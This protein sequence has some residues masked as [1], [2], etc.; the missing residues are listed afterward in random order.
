M[1]IELMRK[2]DYW[3]GIPLTALMTAWCRVMDRFRHRVAL[4]EVTRVLFIELSEMGSAILVDPALRTVAQ[5]HEVYFLIFK[6]NAASLRIF[7]TVADAN[8]CTIR[9]DSLVTLAWDTLRFTIWCRR[10]RID[11][12]VDLELFS[13]VTAILSALSGAAVRIGFHNP[14]SEGLYRGGILTHPVAYNPHV[15][16]A[17]NFVSLSDPIVHPDRYRDALNRRHIGHG[18]VRLAQVRPAEPAIERVRHILRRRIPALMPQHRLFLV[19]ANAGE[20]L[21]QRKWPK[22]HFARFIELFLERNADVLVLLTGSPKERADVEEIA[23]RVNSARCLNIAGDLDFEDLPALYAMA[24]ALLTN[25][26]GPAHFASA[27]GLRTY[28]LFG[29]ETPALYAPLNNSVPIYAGLACSP[30]VTAANHRDTPCQDN[31]CLKLIDPAI[32][33]EKVQA[34]LDDPIRPRPRGEG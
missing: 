33:L 3:C 18:E 34:Y 19:N 30:C 17:R 32:V 11:A 12:A 20:F 13:R 16:I 10:K 29:P 5:R 27:V 6:R 9:E 31:Q 14:R 4:A 28:V 22:G 26:S 2:V 15:H 24:E 25:D 23:S 8:V 1:N 21:P 7:N